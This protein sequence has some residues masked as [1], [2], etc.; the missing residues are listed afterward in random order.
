VGHAAFSDGLG[1][2]VEAMS[3]SLGVRAGRAGGRRWDIGLLVDGV[4][5]S[6]SNK[7]DLRVG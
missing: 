7:F 1:G 6:D 2:T 4:R 3:A 5:Y